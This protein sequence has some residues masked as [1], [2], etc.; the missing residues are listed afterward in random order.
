MPLSAVYLDLLVVLI[1]QMQHNPPNSAAQHEG[2]RDLALRQSL[3]LQ[4]WWSVTK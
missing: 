4:Q 1:L 2:L 3:T